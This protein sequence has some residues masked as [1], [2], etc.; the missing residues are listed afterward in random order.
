MTAMEG[1]QKGALGFCAMTTVG[2]LYLSQAKG[3]W[4]MAFVFSAFLLLRF[5]KTIE[6]EG[7][8]VFQLLSYGIL[9]WNLLIIG[10]LAQGISLINGTDSPLP[11]LLLLLLCDY[12]VRRKNV[13]SVASVLFF[14]FALTMGILLLFSLPAMETENFKFPRDGGAEYLPYGLLPILL[15][16]VYQGKENR[17][18]TPWIWASG[19]LLVGILLSTVGL[20]ASDFY[21]A[22]KSVNLFGTMER[23]EPFVGALTTAGGFCTMALLFSANKN[24]LPIKERKQNLFFEKAQIIPVI[25]S[26][27]LSYKI[28]ET[29][30]AIGTTVCWGVIPVIQQGI[31]IA[32]KSIKK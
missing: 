8:V 9:L 30:I 11:G 31:V 10:R 20:G 32:K 12:G 19:I 23:L 18:S 22:S 4:V 3:L 21:T 2:I 5:G 13:L 14:V 16:Y 15:L 17:R 1:K 24:L 6:E 7:G 29:Y 25:A 27:L 28:P 26:L